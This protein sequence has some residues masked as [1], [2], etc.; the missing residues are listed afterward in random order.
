MSFKPRRLLG[1][2]I[3]LSMSMSIGSG[4][5]AEPRPA[6]DASDTEIAVV[7]EPAQQD[8]IETHLYISGHRV[9]AHEP[10]L[11]ALANAAAFIEGTNN[12]SR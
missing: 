12:A 3:L 2:S 7:P 10:H 4:M 6:S 5:A 8:N 9:Y 11:K 1:A